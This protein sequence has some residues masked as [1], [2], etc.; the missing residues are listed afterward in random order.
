[1]KSLS[2]LPAPQAAAPGANYIV[3]PQYVLVITSYDQPELTGTFTVEIDG[4]FTYP[5]IGRIT[6][7]GMTLREVEA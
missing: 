3:G 7:S 6:V 2:G 1:M 4:S 5:L